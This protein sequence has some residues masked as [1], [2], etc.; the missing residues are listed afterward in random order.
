MFTLEIQ[1]KI[2]IDYT[3]PITDLFA[4][5]TKVY[6]ETTG[7]LWLLSYVEMSSRGFDATPTI[8]T[9]L[10]TWAFNFAGKIS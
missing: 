3:M 2:S 4:L 9:R 6:I 5:M 1:G 7:N 8:D 10:S